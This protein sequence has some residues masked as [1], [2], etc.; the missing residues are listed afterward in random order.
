MGLEVFA[1]KSRW[2]TNLYYAAVVVII[3]CGCMPKGIAMI[4][5][6]FNIRASY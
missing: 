3:A 2:T 4:L 6:D 1:D 5:P